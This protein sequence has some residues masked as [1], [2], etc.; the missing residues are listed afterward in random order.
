MMLST[1]NTRRP[2]AGR[3]C[4]A[5][6]SGRPRVKLKASVSSTICRCRVS[7]GTKSSALLAYSRASDKSAQ[8][9]LAS[10]RLKAV[11][12]AAQT[13]AFCSSVARSCCKAV[14]TMK[15]SNTHA[16]QN[17][18]PKK[19][20]ASG[21]SACIAALARVDASHSRA[22][23]LA[24]AAASTSHS[25]SV[26]CLCLLITADSKN[27]IKSVA[28]SAINNWPRRL[29]ISFVAMDRK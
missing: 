5:Q 4:A 8:A 12:S 21:R 27:T 18:L 23:M 26:R 14:L 11:S 16:A 20:R 6:P 25:H 28:A 10:S 29:K 7:S 19:T 17:A 3:A 1:G 15:P 24:A 2:T 9:P 13:P 22:G